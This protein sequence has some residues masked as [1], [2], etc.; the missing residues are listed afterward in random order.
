LTVTAAPLTIVNTDRSKVYGVTLSNADYTGSI[1]GLVAGD[2]ITVTRASTGDAANATVAGSTYPIVGTLIDAGNRLAN[3]SVT[4]ADRASTVT[5]APLTIVNTDRSKVY[6]VTLSNA[7]Y[8]GSIS[9]LVA[10]DVIT[11]T[12]ASTGDAANATVAG[13]TYP[14]VGT[15]V[16]AGNRLANYSV[17]N[18]DGALTVTA[19]P[20]TVVNT[21]RSKVYGETLSNADYTGS[22]S[23]LVAGDV[24]TVTRAS[25]GDAANATVAGSTYPIVGTLVDAGN[26]LANYSVTNPDGALTVTPR[27]IT[28][29]PT[30]L[31]FKYCGQA[32]P[33]FTY[34]GSE[35][36]LLGN[37]YSGA[38]GRSG[39]NDVGTYGYTL[40]TLS[41]G[42]NY[43]LT[44][45][46]TNTFT[47]TG[48]SID[49]SATSTAIQLGTANKLLS[50]TV[51]SG[52]IPVSNATVTFTVTNNGNIAPITVTTTTNA[53]GV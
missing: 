5:A 14:I 24:I 15:L 38:L 6:G 2:V 44:L 3:Y 32:D 41:A 18:P 49:A 21:S 12:R 11:I 13:S 52:T 4:K 19:A 23:G 36:L 8:T 9:G 10:G 7:D 17:T 34:T 37:S 25:T 16:D 48:V 33:T 39:T 51:T 40:G 47:I 45:D 43:T 42:N 35:Q 31:Q 1:S 30:A 22:I 50:A 20:L 29:I 46:G 27:P 26:R 53:N 28:I